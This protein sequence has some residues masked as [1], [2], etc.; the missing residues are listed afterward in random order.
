MLGAYSHL[1]ILTVTALSARASKAVGLKQVL[2]KRSSEQ[3]VQQR[4]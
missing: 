4:N 1:A 2:L 3:G